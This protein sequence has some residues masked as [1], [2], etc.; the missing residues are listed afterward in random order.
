MCVIQDTHFV[1]EKVKANKPYEYRVVAQNAGGASKP[2]PSSGII[3]AKP[4][5]EA[6]KFDL[7][8]LFGSKDIRVKAG[9]P[10]KISLGCQGSPTPTVTWANDG[11]PIVDSPKVCEK[12]F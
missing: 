4:L 5:K 11:N 10:L 1:D 2:S 3:K 9:E 8:G 6:P 12:N 7:T